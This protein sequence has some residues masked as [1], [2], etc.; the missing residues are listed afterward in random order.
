[1]K[2]A[3]LL[4]TSIASIA[5]DGG[6][7]SHHQTRG[8][9]A[10]LGDVSI[11]VCA[12]TIAE[13]LYGLYVSPSI[14]RQRHDA[15]RQALEQYHVWDVDRHTA[16]VYA[17][18]RGRLFELYAPR[19]RK[20]RLTAKQ[21]EDL[22]DRTMAKE[23]GIQENDLWVLSVAVQ[24]DLRF[25]TSDKKMQRILDVAKEIHGYDRALVWTLTP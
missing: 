11:S 25:L 8:G 2:D 4:D 16:E 10:A 19:D 24:Y 18:I 6:H 21:P 5:W 3:Y 20:G 22:R 14:D 12:I 17:R 9:L 13:V 15:V 23:L 7:P 1:M